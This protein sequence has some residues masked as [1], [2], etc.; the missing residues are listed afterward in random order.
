MLNDE[1]IASRAIIIAT[2]SHPARSSIDG[3]ADMSYLTNED[4]FELTHL[5]AS[6]LIVGGGPV[7]VELG[8][9]L[10]RVGVQV[11]LLQGPERL[12]PREEPEVSAAITDVLRSEGV[13][14]VTGTRVLRVEQ[15]GEKKRVTVKQGEQMVAFEADEILLAAGRQPNVAGLNLDAIGI[16]YNEKG[17]KV[18]D[19][20]RTSVANN[21]AIGDVIGGYLFTHAA[22]YQ[23]GVAVRNALL[24]VGRKKVDYR[25]MPWCTFTDPE[26]GHVGLTYVEAQQRHR[27]VR[28]V[29]FPWADI[30]RAQTEH[31]T[32]GFM[33]LILAGKKDEIVGAHM[34][35]ERAGELLGEIALA[36]Q[37]HLTISAL[38]ATTHPYPTYSTGLQQ[39]IFEAYLSSAQLRRNRTIVKT[40]MRLRK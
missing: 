26:V 29:T 40:A 24:P 2:G 6:L 34:V 19:Y 32:I 36:M 35:G 15:R 7:G 38:L 11:T 31:A 5:P 37:N 13:K 14:I 16:T 30:D 21:F 22:A 28:V 1:K 4:V 39:A 18:D 20:L 3:L 10:A 27:Q 12:L 25:V 8:Q 17:I 33:K 9:A 23:A